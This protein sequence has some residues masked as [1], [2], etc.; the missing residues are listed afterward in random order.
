M[1]RAYDA[2]EAYEVYFRD[3]C[4]A[5]G[6]CGDVLRRPRGLG[7]DFE[8]LPLK[9]PRNPITP[10][11]TSRVSTLH[12]G[13]YKNLRE[14]ARRVIGATAKPL[15][16]I[17]GKAV[18]LDRR[19]PQ[20][21]LLEGGGPSADGGRSSRRWKELSDGGRSSRWKESATPLAPLLLEQLEQHRRGERAGEIIALNQID[22]PF[23]QQRDLFLGLHTLG[24]DV[25]AHAL[26]G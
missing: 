20:T 26:E 4:I 19:S 8:F 6:L 1:C 14:G 23:F 10:I 25:I 17:G 11:E 16:A 18:G 13:L 12:P 2:Y 9:S 21:S 22:V 3:D 24:D 7:G 5:C 15:Y